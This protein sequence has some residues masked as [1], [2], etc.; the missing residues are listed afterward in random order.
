MGTVHTVVELLDMVPTALELVG[1]PV[2]AAV[3]GRSL[4]PALRGD[5]LDRLEIALTEHEHW[6]SV[7]S[8]SHHYVV[9]ADGTERLWDLD[10]DPTEHRDLVP[11]G[12]L[13]VERELARH[14]HLLLRRQLKARRG[15]PRSFPY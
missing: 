1:V 12:G 9:H 7:R 6:T 11:S 4:V 2:P 13:L 10:Q 15:L 8:A 5:R 14:R 3:Q